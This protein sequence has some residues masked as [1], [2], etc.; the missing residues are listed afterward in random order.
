MP[1]R[2]LIVDDEPSVL[3]LLR[4]YL[5]RLGH[6]VDIASNAEQALT[7]VERSRGAYDLVIADLQLPDLN[8]EEM[9]RQMR[10]HHPQLNALIS[11]GHPSPSASADPSSRRL[12]I[13]KPFLPQELADRISEIL[14]SRK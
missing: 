1:A 10:Y 14:D 8:G 6:S 7:L 4:R 9:I 11:S 13:Q 3:E 5:E 2:L 12:F